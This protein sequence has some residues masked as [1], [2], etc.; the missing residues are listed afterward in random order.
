MSPELVRAIKEI[1]E[2]KATYYERLGRDVSSTET[3]GA[4]NELT[5]ALYYRWPR[6]RA[7]LTGEP[8]TYEGHTRVISRHPDGSVKSVVCHKP[9]DPRP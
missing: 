1:D 5:N 2:L 4:W 8:L 3:K 9:G 6:I 7:A